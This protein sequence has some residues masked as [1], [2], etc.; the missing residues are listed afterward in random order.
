MKRKR[1][2]KKLSELTGED[3]LLAYGDRFIILL[4]VGLAVFLFFIVKWNLTGEW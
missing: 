2:R 3:L 4:G 1:V